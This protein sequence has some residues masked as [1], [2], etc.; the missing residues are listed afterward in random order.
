MFDLNGK[1]VLVIGLARTGLATSLFCARHGA[2]V[3]AID[4]RG[5]S[6]LADAAGKL[7]ASRI[8]V[9]LGDVLGEE[10]FQQDLVVPSPGVPADSPLLQSLRARGIIVW[11]EIE[12]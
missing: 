5:E 3:T 2:V 8:K 12:L 4:K 11:S 10:I 7:R 6:E 1:R 9:I